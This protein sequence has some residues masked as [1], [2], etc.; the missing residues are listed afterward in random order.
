MH[1]YI[2]QFRQVFVATTTSSPD[3]LGTRLVA[4]HTDQF[5]HI[6][7]SSQ[8]L[9]APQNLSQHELANLLITLINHLSSQTRAFHVLV[10]KNTKLN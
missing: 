1:Q 10:P 5:S 4:T 6:F 3:V 8:S 2:V 9:A 7:L